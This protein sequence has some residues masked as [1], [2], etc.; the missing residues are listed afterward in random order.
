MG[1]LE[2]QLREADVREGK[3]KDRAEDYARKKRAA[4]ERMSAH[5]VPLCIEPGCLVCAHWM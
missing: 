5:E 1:M 2:E 3:I 4:K